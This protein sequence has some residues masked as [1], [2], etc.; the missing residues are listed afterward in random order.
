MPE[1]NGYTA[2]GLIHES[3]PEIPI[4]AQT[5]YMDDKIKAME[6]GCSGFLIK[7][8]DRKSFLSALREFL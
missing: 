5:A 6:S 8:F 4:I 1:M 2:S 7:P 3:K